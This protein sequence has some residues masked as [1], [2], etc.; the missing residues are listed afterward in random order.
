MSPKDPHSSSG[1]RRRETLLQTTDTP[2]S[3]RL[4]LVA[5][6]LL[7]GAGLLLPLFQKE[8]RKET[9]TADAVLRAEN[10]HETLAQD[11]E[12]N[13]PEPTEFDRLVAGIDLS[14][15][16]Q[17]APERLDHPEFDVV[18]GVTLDYL[19]WFFEAVGYTAEQIEQGEAV[20]VPP[21]VALSI[22]PGWADGISVPLKKSVF[23]RAVLPLV[24]L[25]NE[26]VLNDRERLESYRRKRL[27]RAPISPAEHEDA[28]SLAVRYGVLPADSQASLEPGD[29]EE[30]LRRVDTVPPSLALG[31]A[32]YESGYGTSRFATTGNALFG[33]WAWDDSALRP[34]NQRESLGSYGVRAFDS[35]IESVRAYLFNLNT[36]RVYED[37]RR[38]RERQRA[39]KPGPIEF[40]GLALAGTLQEYSERRQAYVDDLQGIMRFNGLDRAD[41]LRLVPGD[42]VYFE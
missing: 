19:T 18:Q 5:G 8:T 39:G 2:V 42:P 30:L 1:R 37:F 32:A 20:V 23:Y 24:L 3:R 6:V 11:A 7:L 26:A 34:E 9:A 17:P 12:I 14:A 25:E 29:L 31:Q 33:Q 21:V 38:Q 41:G 15:A 10:L 40:D 28:R 13:P 16:P 4:L 27:N 22:Q 35:P 36:H